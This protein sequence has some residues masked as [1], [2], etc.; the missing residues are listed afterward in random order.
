[1]AAKGIRVAGN[2]DPNPTPPG[3]PEPAMKSLDQIASTGIPPN[4]ILHHPRSV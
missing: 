2:E 4:P 3:T 1:M